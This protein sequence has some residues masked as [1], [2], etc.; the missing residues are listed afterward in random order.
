MS[1]IIVPD[2]PVRLP[3]AMTLGE[4]VDVAV[5]RDPRKI[6]L[7]YQD[8]RVAYQDFREDSLRTARIF[9]ELG[10]KHGDRV[11]VFLPNGPE[12]LYIWMGLSRLGAICVPINTAYKE[13]ETAYIINN[14]EAKALVSHHSLLDVA[15]GAAGQCTSLKNRLVVSQDG[16]PYATW[17]DYAALLAE[18]SPL[19]PQAC[20]A[21]SPQDISML[22]YTSG[23]TGPPKGV[24][25]T[26]E[27]YVAAGQGF[28]HMDRG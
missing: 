10:V 26:H 24:I 6:Y 28:R 11:C 2:D 18:A 12:F 16:E 9:Q 3:W 15:N 4:L 17:E 8:H 23:T 14:A 5:S 25:I 19:P 22:V 7:C 20:E 13:A 21:V 27:M 1:N